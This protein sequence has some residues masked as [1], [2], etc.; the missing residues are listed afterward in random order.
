MAVHTNHV[1]VSNNCLLLQA[2]HQSAI[3]RPYLNGIYLSQI[4]ENAG[5]TGLAWHALENVPAFAVSRRR[6]G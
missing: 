3:F 2:A 4:S 5:M 1:L 6:L